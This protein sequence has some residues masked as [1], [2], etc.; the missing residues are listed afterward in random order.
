M[1]LDSFQKLLKL[2]FLTFMLV[3]YGGL[4][5]YLGKNFKKPTPKVQGIKQ[6]VIKA[7]IDSPVPFADAQSTNL[8]GSYV[9]I[10]ANTT[11]AYEVS[12][13]KDWFSSYNQ[14]QEK[15]QFFA[16]YSFVVPKDTANFKI[17]IKLE[18]IRLDDWETTVKF[19]EN[20]NDFYNVLTVEN[21]EIVGRPAKKIESQSTPL[22]PEQGMT[23]TTYLVFD[24]Q[25]PLIA[26]YQQISKD[27]DP[28]QGKQVLYEMV[29]S[30]KFN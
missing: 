3:A 27:E 6:N 2:A 18:I 4:T 10:C 5:F 17:P 9:K 23:K 29:R 8:I 26:T 28:S 11:Y 16:P 24:N 13:P 14:D 12:Y 25:K 20:P 7:P 21:V 15:C 30:L 19:H 22:S 1:T